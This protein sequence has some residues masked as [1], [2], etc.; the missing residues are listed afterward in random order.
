[1]RIESAILRSTP[2]P[3]YFEA[4]SFCHAHRIDDIDELERVRLMLCVRE[5]QRRTQEVRNSAARF[6]AMLPL[7]LVEPLDDYIRD[8]VWPY[9][10]NVARE[11]QLELGTMASPNPSQTA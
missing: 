5:Y 8:I 11:L 4:R 2:A 9:C 10:A 1:M 6:A 7:G 3:M